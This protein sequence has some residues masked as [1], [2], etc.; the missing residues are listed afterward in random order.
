MSVEEILS[1]I[2]SWGVQLPV[3]ATFTLGVVWKV[4][5]TRVLNK[6]NGT[7]AIRLKNNESQVAELETELTKE[8]AKVKM[9]EERIVELEQAITI[10]A[11]V[12]RNEKVKALAKQTYN[13]TSEFINDIKEIAQEVAPVIKEEVQKVVLKRND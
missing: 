10:I 5:Q 9:L 1:I 7:N 13:K 2:T 11:N 4:I 12:S 3:W 8:Q 6:N